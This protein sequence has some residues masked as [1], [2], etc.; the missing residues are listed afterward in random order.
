MLHACLSLHAPFF[1]ANWYV[2]QPLHRGVCGTQGMR[3]VYK[4]LV[5]NLKGKDYS[6]DLGVDGWIILTLFLESQVWRMCTALIW[7]IIGTGP[8]AGSCEHDNELWGSVQ[9]GDFLDYKVKVKGKVVPVIKYAPRH[10]DVLGEWK[11][12]ST[13]S[14]ARY[15][16][17]QLHGSV[18]LPPGKEPLVPIG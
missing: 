3:N 8:A 17:D 7:L 2:I 1:Y 4:I 15:W 16:S 10:E 6:E 11:Y 13:H 18:A 5:A 12:S 14:W 9:G